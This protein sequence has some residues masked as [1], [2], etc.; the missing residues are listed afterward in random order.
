M[1][2]LLGTKHFSPIFSF[3]FSLCPKSSETKE[4]KKDDSR[5]RMLLQTRKTRLLSSG[6]PVS[7]AGRMLLCHAS[8]ELLLQQSH[9]LVGFS[10]RSLHHSGNGLHHFMERVERFL[11]VSII[12]IDLLWFK[13]LWLESTWINWFLLLILRKINLN[14]LIDSMNHLNHL[15]LIIDSFTGSR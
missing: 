15:I 1:N 6:A 9:I 11:L 5:K 4:R 14:Q 13:I 2:N 3:S 10:G 8:N 12:L 7:H